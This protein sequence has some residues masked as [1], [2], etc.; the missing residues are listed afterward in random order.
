MA[1]ITE[2]KKLAWCRSVI[3]LFTLNEWN[4][5]EMIF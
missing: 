4:I 5:D 3:Q 2:K 1:A